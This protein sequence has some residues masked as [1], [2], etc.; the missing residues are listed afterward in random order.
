VQLLRELHILDAGYAC[1]VFSKFNEFGEKLQVRDLLDLVI[2]PFR[3]DL[4]DQNWG[5]VVA[6]AV[7]KCTFCSS[8]E[9]LPIFEY[10]IESYTASRA[11]RRKCEDLKPGSFVDEWR[12]T[13]FNMWARF[14]PQDEAFEYCWRACF[15]EGH[16]Q[17]FLLGESVDQRLDNLH[18]LVL[19]PMMEHHER[20]PFAWRG[21]LIRFMR[22]V[23]SLVELHRGQRRRAPGWLD[24]SAARQQE[25][26]DVLEECPD[27]VP[28]VVTGMVDWGE[29]EWDVLDPIILGLPAD[30]VIAC[31]EQYASS[32]HPHTSH[33]HARRLLAHLE[34]A[35]SQV[36]PSG[37]TDASML[38]AVESLVAASRSAAGSR[39]SDLWLGNWTVENLWT[40]A[41][42]AATAE[43]QEYF[44]SQYGQDEHE[45]V[46][47]LA[48]A[49]ARH[50]NGTNAIVNAWLGRGDCQK[51]LLRATVRRFPKTAPANLPQEGGRRGVQAD[52]AILVKADMPGLAVA[53]RVTLIQA[54]KIAKARNGVWESSC[55]VNLTQLRRLV[56]LSPCA[57]YVFFAHS[58]LG[59]GPSI[60]PAFLIQDVCQ[61]QG[62][63]KAP[64][65]LILRASKS[66]SVFLIQDMIG[67]W[68]GDPR[69]GVLALA[70]GGDTSGHGA[71]VVLEVRVSREHCNE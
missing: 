14:L 23:L 25:A 71:R 64:V 67:L 61:A 38:G 16:Q 1:R 9:Y 10:G 7:E 41:A 29:D 6:D 43:F 70:E 52:L 55:S 57:H 30:R 53:D 39:R 13:F 58:E 5:G 24:E 63:P 19:R 40:A 36:S 18:Q 27:L 44:D 56:K 8:D 17:D 49:L 3:D 66:L 59:P 69:K 31:L 46:A 20:G 48:D 42:D 21:A 65:P 33:Y 45:H 26:I 51:A 60:L 32:H 34:G 11:F 54:K 35:V 50:L 4:D 62:S 2:R 37:A 15:A 12:Q 22:P 47:V 68:T 28:V